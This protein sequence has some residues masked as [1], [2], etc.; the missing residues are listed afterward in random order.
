[1]VAKIWA[2]AVGV[3]ELALIELLTS[4]TW[5]HHPKIPNLEHIPTKVDL[6]W[7]LLSIPSLRRFVYQNRTSNFG[8]PLMAG[9]NSA[10]VF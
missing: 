8:S 7:K 3:D 6:K 9:L 10:A 1:M 2:V 5:I 4:Q